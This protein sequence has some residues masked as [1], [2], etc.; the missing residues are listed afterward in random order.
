MSYTNPNISTTYQDKLIAAQIIER[1][2]GNYFASQ[3]FTDSLTLSATKG[4][5]TRFGETITIEKEVDTTYRTFVKGNTRQYDATP[6]ITKKQLTYDQSREVNVKYDDYD[7]ALYN[8]AFL[9]NYLQSTARTFAVGMETDICTRILADT[10]IPV[11]NTISLSNFGGEFG[12]EV[13]NAAIEKLENNGMTSGRRVRAVIDPTRAR[14]YRDSLT[15]YN[16]VGD[17]AN[18]QF[19]DTRLVS[20]YGVEL[21]TALNSGAFKR[22]PNAST[23]DG[24]SGTANIVGFFIAENTYMIN[25]VNLP[26]DLEGVTA[27]TAVNPNVPLP[28]RFIRGYDQDT[29][30]RKWGY[31]VLWG[32]VNLYP[33]LVVPIVL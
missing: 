3:I 29:K 22:L 6:N 27:V 5:G 24:V 4:M 32:D 23:S 17:A 11:G 1:L 25:G 14:Q 19:L 9:D 16:V 18:R 33:E 10:D 7:I 15:S 12:Y 28:L 20:S 31:D 2:S 13:V 8:E 26:T 30:E 21:F